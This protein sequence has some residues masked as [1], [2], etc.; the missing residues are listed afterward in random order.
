MSDVRTVISDP[1]RQ[2]CFEEIDCNSCKILFSEREKPLNYDNRFDLTSMKV[3]SEKDQHTRLQQ[4]NN[5]RNQ[6]DDHDT[7]GEDD[8][9]KDNNGDSDREDWSKT[10]DRQNLIFQQQQNTENLF[11]EDDTS[12]EENNT[13]CK[14][15]KRPEVLTSESESDNNYDSYMDTVDAMSY[16]HLSNKSVNYNKKKRINRKNQHSSHDSD[17]RSYSS[18]NSIEISDEK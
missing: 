2:I 17:R 15:R 4:G 18:R 12:R 3:L 14:K 16:N 13:R 6:I 11:N 1:N 7:N 10:K 5:G 9:Q 8:V